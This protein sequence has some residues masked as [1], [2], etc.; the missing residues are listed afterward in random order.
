MNERGSK[1]PM[2]L[3]ES[4]CWIY[5]ETINIFEKPSNRVRLLLTDN[6][7]V[8]CDVISRKSFSAEVYEDDGFLV[9]MDKY[10]I[11][12]GHTLVIPKKH[13]NNL[14]F[15]PCREV[16][17]LYSLVPIIA[18]AVISAVNADGFNVGQNNGKAANQIVPHVHVHVIPRFNDDSQN[19]RWP[20]RHV[21]SY[22]ELT[23]IAE[24]IKRVLNPNLVKEFT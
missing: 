4:I 20:A 8:F 9:L 15:M 1:H 6:S 19:G 16:G 14:L 3:L 5:V 7:C 10:P 17:K 21:A 13:Y 12:E 22:E 23:K 18:R 2:C 24:R 11:T